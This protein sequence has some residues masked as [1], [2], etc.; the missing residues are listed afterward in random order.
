MS[1][2]HQLKLSHKFLILGLLTLIMI[3][4]PTAMYVSYVLAETR[5]AHLEAQGVPPLIALNKT[6]QQVQVH[7][8]LSAGMLAGSDVLAAQRP[9]A[10]DSVVALISQVDARLKESDG[11]PAVLTSWSKIKQTWQTLEQAVAAKQLQPAESLAQHTQLIAAMFQLNDDLLNGYGL[12]LDPNADTYF[13]IQASMVQANTLAEKLGLMRGRG[14]GA[15]ASKV[16]EPQNKGVFIAL[17]G[18]VLDLST[19]AFRSFDLALENNLSFKQ[20]LKDKLEAQKTQ[21]AKAVQLADTH[22]V[23]AQEMSF[24]ATE[25]FNDFT[26]TI[27]ALHAVNAVA[28]DAVEQA[29]QARASRAEHLLIAVAVGLAVTLT[30]FALLAMA[31]VRSITEPVSQAVQLANEVAS[32]NLSGHT[33]AQGPNEMGQLIE[34]LGAMRAKFGQVVTDVRRG[35]ESVATASAEIA[36][37]NNDLS[38]RTET[39]ASALEET[40]ASM[41]Q[42]SSTVKHNADNARQA[43]QMAMNASTVAIRGGEA[44]TQ[45]VDTMRGINDSSKKISDIIGVIDGIAFQTNILALNAAVEAARAGEQGRGFAVVASEVRSLAGRSAEAAKEIKSLI[46]VSVERVAQGSALVDQAGAT[47]SEVVGAIRRVTDIMGEIS[48]SSHEQSLGVAQVGEA[49]TQMDHATQQNAAMVEQIAAAASGLN[50]QADDLVQVV[51]V[52]TLK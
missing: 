7:R 45:V 28:I 9:A 24:S 46:G 34:A 20:A 10:R 4:L 36:A 52:F 44:M 41:D 17:K 2:L 33:V 37:G 27:N 51:S 47:M 22:I 18:Q 48:A 26:Q 30:A 12:S 8:G 5:A 39:Q 42:L 3:A 13:L 29:L 25:Y 15:L 50:Q 32:G 43:N 23:H 19:E 14:T 1:V 40:A 11:S 21:I 38:A 31:F 6:V 35:S 16:L 49:V